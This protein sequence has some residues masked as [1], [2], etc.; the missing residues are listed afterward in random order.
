MM[1]EMLMMAAKSIPESQIDSLKNGMIKMGHQLAFSQKM[2]IKLE[3]GED[4]VVVMWVFTEAG[5]VVICPVTLAYHNGTTLH[6]REL[7]DLGF[8]LTKFI[9]E[10]DVTKL[11]SAISESNDVK[12]LQMIMDVLK[13]AKNQSKLDTDV[14][15]PTIGEEPGEEPGEQPGI[16]PGEEPGIEPYES[17]QS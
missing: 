16:E 5:E 2:A 15:E 3:D 10:L 8:S 13:N 11:I 1:K 14:E 9:G 17:Y 12:Q 4:D 6:K 7:V